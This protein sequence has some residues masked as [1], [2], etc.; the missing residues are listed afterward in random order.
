M[1][2][3]TIC[4]TGKPYYQACDNTGAISLP[5]YQSA[6]FAHP[7]LG[8]STGYDYSRLKNPTRDYLEKLVASLDHAE[9]GFAFNCGLAAI[10]ALFDAVILNENLGTRFHVICSDD[11]YGGTER[12]L[13]TIGLKLG[14]DTTYVDTSNLENIKSARKENTKIIF[15][16]TPGNPLMKVTDIRT[17]AEFAHSIGALL[18]VDNTFLTPYLQQPLLLGA[19]ISVQS[20]TKFLCGHNDTLAG[21][22]TTNDKKLAENLEI[23]TKTTGSALPPFDSFLAVRGIKTLAVRMEKHCSNAKKIAAFLEN[24]PKVQKVL[25]AGKG[26]MISFYVD[27]VAT[28]EKVLKSVK[29]IHFAESLGGVDSLITY[30]KTQTHV[31]VPEKERNARGITD[32]LLR[33][34]VG[35]E[36]PD[37]LIKDLGEAL[38]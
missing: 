3:D 18:I 12:F 1:N 8:K 13:N 22:V 28:V 2:I 19:D 36:N 16:E 24:H 23:I 27:S 10:T 20:G 38:G 34:S 5:I 4:V 33:L 30:P 26:S 7:E 32:K 17:T 15:V 9:F 14:F 25:F 31:D 6:T 11:L 29:V 37:D 35:I 21:F